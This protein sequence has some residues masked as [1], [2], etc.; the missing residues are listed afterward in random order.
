MHPV[1]DDIIFYLETP[2]NISKTIQANKLN[3]IS[4]CKVGTERDIVFLNYSPFHPPFVGL[5]MEPRPLFY[6]S[7]A[8]LAQQLCF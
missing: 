4:A 5:E 8:P 1:K 6:H 3:K 2:K 7:A